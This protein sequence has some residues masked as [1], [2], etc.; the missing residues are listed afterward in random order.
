MSQLVLQKFDAPFVDTALPWRGG[1][2]YMG[3]KLKLFLQ[4]FSVKELKD[5]GAVDM[6]S[7]HPPQ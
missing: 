5:L 7:P 4:K 6:R 3:A 2:R 1:V